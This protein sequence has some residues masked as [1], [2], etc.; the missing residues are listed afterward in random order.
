VDWRTST[1]SFSNGNC[2]EVASLNGG[3]VVRDTK[4]RDGA[5]LAIP[6]EAWR[7]FILGFRV[8]TRTGD[9]P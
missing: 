1:F 2:V 9:T 8:P 4:D 5:V 7:E 6:A 3:A